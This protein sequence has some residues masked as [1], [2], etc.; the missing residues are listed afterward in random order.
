MS[1]FTGLLQESPAQKNAWKSSLSPMPVCA[2]GD[3]VDEVLWEEFPG[4]LRI[5]QQLQT[6][7]CEGHASTHAAIQAAYC[8]SGQVYDLSPWF[9]YLMAQ[10]MGGNFGRDNGAYLGA[11]CK[12]AQEIGYAPEKLVPNKG[13]YYTQIPAEAMAEASKVKALHTV[14]I[15]SGG[16]DALRLLLGQQMGAGVFAVNW[17][18]G[19][20]GDGNVSQYRPLG[21]GGHAMAWIALSTKKDSHG[22]P[23]V[24]C[25]NS[26]PSFTTYLMS[27]TA[28]QQIVDEDS[29]GCW[30]VSTMSVMK[31]VVDWRQQEIMA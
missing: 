28:V 5:R 19:K 25:A 29:W 18:I 16:Y 6:N 9:S 17:P 26:H 22:R 12:A 31:P 7:S 10:K 4:H 24:W 1:D 3:L 8:Q 30:G 13:Y 2:P 11:G 23:W 21:G 20:D 15:E 14:D 27:P